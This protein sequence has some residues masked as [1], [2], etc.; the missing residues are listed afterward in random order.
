[1]FHYSDFLF[2]L[3]NLYFI[4]HEKFLFDYNLFTFDM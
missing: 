1:M 2:K 4:L 3:P